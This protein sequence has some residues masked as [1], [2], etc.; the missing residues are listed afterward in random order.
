MELKAITFGESD[1]LTA[2]AKKNEKSS[3]HRRSIRF[4]L[5]P[6]DEENY[7]SPGQSIYI[8]G[9]SIKELKALIEWLEKPEGTE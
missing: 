5:A 9:N 4:T 2:V 7:H 8:S 3:L 6:I 1:F